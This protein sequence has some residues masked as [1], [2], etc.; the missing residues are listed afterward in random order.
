MSQVR[1]KN[2]DIFR[3][4][5]PENLPQVHFFFGNYLMTLAKQSKPRTKK[6]NAVGSRKQWIQTEK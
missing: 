2:N 1:A 3:L 4:H 6:E 5:R